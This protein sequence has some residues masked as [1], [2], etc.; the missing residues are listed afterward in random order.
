MLIGQSLYWNRAQLSLL[1]HVALASSRDVT[2]THGFKPMEAYLPYKICTII[3]WKTCDNDC[4]AMGKQSSGTQQR[5]LCHT[6]QL[7]GF[8]PSNDKTTRSREISKA[9]D[10]D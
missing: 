1:S 10:I 5:A 9:R 4:V 8:Y 2:L 6:K 3:R 7:Q